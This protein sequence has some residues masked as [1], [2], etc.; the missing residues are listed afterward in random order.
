MLWRRLFV[1]IFV[2]SLGTTT[3]VAQRPLSPSVEL[4]T[5][6]MHATFRIQGP[7]KGESNKI[8]FGTVFIMG[9][10]ITAN[11]TS[12][13]IVLV[14]AAHVLDDI[15][16]EVATLIV[17]RKNKD[18]T[19]TAYPFN[20][21]IRSGGRPLY[22]THK[23]AD[24][25]AMYTNL[26]EDV[27]ITGLSPSFLPDDKRLEEI[28][29]HPGDEAFVLGFPLSLGIPGGFPM[30]RSGRIASF[31]LTP[32]KTVGRFFFDV[33]LF[34]GNS[35]GP[36]YYTYNNRV[37]KGVVRT[38]VV[39]GVLGLVTQERRSNIPEFKDRSLSFGVVVPAAFIREAIDMLPPLN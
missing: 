17:R 31:P 36:V 35:G 9:I 4:N 27:P 15:G 3:S 24:V 38:G 34:G 25:S 28:E 37:S 16:G 32:M 13:N 5:L 1:S 29:L 11:S 14:T 18:G 39:Q 8:S 22:V 10:P 6:L 12:A 21:A 7:K 20:I 33:L 26:P 2:L 23:T 19:Y 30:L